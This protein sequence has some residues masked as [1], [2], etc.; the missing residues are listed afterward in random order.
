MATRRERLTTWWG[1]ST[2]SPAQPAPDTWAVQARALAWAPET[3]GWCGATEQLVC[4]W[5]AAAAA[6]AQAGVRPKLVWAEPGAPRPQPETQQPGLRMGAGITGPGE[7]RLS[8]F[9]VGLENTNLWPWGAWDGRRSG[10]QNSLWRK[11]RPLPRRTETLGLLWIQAW[12]KVVCGWALQTVA[13]RLPRTRLK[14]PAQ[15]GHKPVEQ[16]ILGSPPQMTVEGGSM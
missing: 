13:R 2:C 4:F 5:V 16:G 9:L 12:H 6:T 14:L 1:G 8:T 7:L 10:C 11:P 15:H 3:M